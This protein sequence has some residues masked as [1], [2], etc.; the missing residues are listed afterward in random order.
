MPLHPEHDL[1]TSPFWRLDKSK[2]LLFTKY[3]SR[4]FKTVLLPCSFDSC[5]LF[6]TCR[7]TVYPHCSALI[8]E[9]PSKQHY[10]HVMLFLL[11]VVLLYNL[12]FVRLACTWAIIDNGIPKFF[13][14]LFTTMYLTFY[15]KRKIVHRLEFN[16]N[17]SIFTIYGFKIFLL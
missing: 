7:L 4:E 16:M 9:P 2:T 17:F 6:H 12:H 14:Y 13:S 5:L 8:V 1:E 11:P 3:F 10:V 15:P